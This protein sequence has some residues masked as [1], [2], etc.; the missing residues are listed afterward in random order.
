[1]KTIYIPFEEV[2]PFL[3]LP[4]KA[5]IFLHLVRA[6]A[7]N[8][9]Y[10]LYLAGGP[11]RD[12]LLKRPVKDLDLVL[13]GDW[14]ELLPE[15]LKEKGL[16]LLFQS[17]FLT[18][19]LKIDEGFT[20]DLVT[21]R[22]EIY[23]EPAH[24]PRIC[25]SDFKEDIFRRDFTINALIYGLTPPYEETLVDLVSGL[26]DL[27]KGLIRPLHLKSFVDDPTRAFRG[28]RYKV[29]LRFDFAEEIYLALSEADKVSSFKKL[30]AQRLINELLLFLFKESLEDLPL[31]L[32]ETK[33]LKLLNRTGLVLRKISPKDFEIL[34]LALI[35]LS[36][37]EAEKFFLLFLVEISEENLKRLGFS[38][39][40]RLRLL[41][42]W[43][44]FFKE[45]SFF[46]LGIIEKVEVLEKL[47]LYFVFRLS[48]E[49]TYRE[50]ILKFLKEL[51]FVK[52]EVTG[53]DLLSM[54][55]KEGE[56]IGKILK[57][58]RRRRIEGELRS[59]EEE[60]SFVK[61]LIFQS[62]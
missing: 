35:E 52:P 58:L 2:K 56:T 11:V 40:E 51:R 20:L 24:L 36:R 8:K 22:K 47:P 15:I 41:N 60:L 55:V 33:R 13:E 23:P 31:L 26:A 12:F 42:W 38:E 30:S 53:Y 6:L 4:P 49:E 45:D 1:M 48:L 61:T 29:R 39:K 54:G 46:K 27:K 5:F 14:K 25:P 34:E 21:A 59:K 50:F 32:E 37:K 7:R 19:K 3:D 16:T 62:F 17:P 28:V 18:Y 57:E 44:Y 9:G 43:N 10:F